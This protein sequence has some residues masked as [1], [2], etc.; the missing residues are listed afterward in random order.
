MYEKYL[1]KA[2][3]TLYFSVCENPIYV[4]AREVIT[5]IDWIGSDSLQI[6]QVKSSREW[7]YGFSKDFGYVRRIKKKIE[8]LHVKIS[9]GLYA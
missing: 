2:I 8:H 1:S 9:K 6:H 7:A 3:Q 5:K 4:E